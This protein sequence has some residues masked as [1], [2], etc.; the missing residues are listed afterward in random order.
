MKK[1]SLTTTSQVER[2]Y[3]VVVDE[4]LDEQA[5]EKQ[6]KKRLRTYLAD[7]A[8]IGAGIVTMITEQTRDVTSQQIRMV[9]Q[10]AVAKEKVTDPVEE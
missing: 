10:Q 3:E 4:N 5:A 7:P 1:L 8:I 2:T 9:E 6:A